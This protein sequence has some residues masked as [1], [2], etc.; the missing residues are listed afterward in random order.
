MLYLSHH[1]LLIVKDQ[2]VCLRTSAICCI[3]DAVHGAAYAVCV[4]EL[5]VKLCKS[6]CCLMKCNFPPEWYYTLASISRSWVQCVS[7]KVNESLSFNEP[8]NTLL[9]ATL[10]L[11]NEWVRVYYARKRGCILGGRQV[12]VLPTSTVLHLSAWLQGEIKMVVLACRTA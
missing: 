5:S 4:Y 3:Q 10:R 11:P 1:I 12:Q 7:V 2:Y 6:K 9:S 8:I